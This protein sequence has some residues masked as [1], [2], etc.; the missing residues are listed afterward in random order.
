MGPFVILEMAV[1]VDPLISVSAAHDIAG[2]VA[3][4]LRQS[5][6][7]VAQALVTTEPAGARQTS[8]Y[9]GGA[10]AAAGAA[11]ADEG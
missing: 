1:E 8:A 3:A 10:A 2:M 6:E 9:R 7:E 11:A 4:Q 5:H